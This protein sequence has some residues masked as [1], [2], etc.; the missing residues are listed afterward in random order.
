[1]I[2]HLLPLRICR[3][4]KDNPDLFISLGGN[5]DERGTKAY[6]DQLSQKRAQAIQDYLVAQ[7]IDANKIVIFAFGKDHPVKTGHTEADWEYNRRV[8]IAVWDATPTPEQAL[9]VTPN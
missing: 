5:A 7:G 9:G 8:D 4:L 3:I 2:K 1:M 6:N